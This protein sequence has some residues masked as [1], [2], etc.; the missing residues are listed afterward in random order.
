MQR[1]RDTMLKKLLLTVTVSLLIVAC[2]DDGDTDVTS[3][4]GTFKIE[5]FDSPP[6]DSVEN[7][8]VTITEVTVHKSGGAWDTLSQPEVTLDFLELING[9]T[10]VL[11]NESLESGDYTQLRLVVADSNEVVINGE[12]FPLKIPSGE[13]SGVKL[14]LNFSILDDE[15]IEIY[16]DFDASKSITWTPGKYLLRPTFKAFKK[17]ISGT[18][19]GTVQDSA[20]IGIPNALVEA[21]G[22]DDT[23]S[24][25]TDST[26]AYKLILLEDT[27][28]LEASADGYT[29]A[30][31]MYTSLDVQAEAILTGFNFV[32]Q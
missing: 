11:V 12:T 28:S 24:T 27:Y 15:I 21:V 18:V 13:Q 6:P 14:N 32:L 1:V 20:E 9:K 4:S 30:D 3:G 5:V 8:F 16:L 26:G 22:S 17:I 31:T 19:A 25:V 7:I 10:S 23:T 29:S 2:E